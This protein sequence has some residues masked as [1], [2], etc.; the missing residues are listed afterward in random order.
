MNAVN[1]STTTD[2]GNLAST[3]PTQAAQSTNVAVCNGWIMDLSIKFICAVLVSNN[4]LFTTFCIL[5]III[6]YN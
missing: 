6:I 3:Y 1:L 4:A 5:I 2:R